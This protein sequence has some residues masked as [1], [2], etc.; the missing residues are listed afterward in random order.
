MATSPESSRKYFNPKQLAPYKPEAIKLKKTKKPTFI[1]VSLPDR[2][3]IAN[4]GA[5]SATTLFYFASYTR[6]SP[7]SVEEAERSFISVTGSLEQGRAR[8]QRAVEQANRILE[9]SHS[10]WRVVEKEIPNEEGQTKRVIYM[11]RKPKPKSPTAL[12]VDKKIR[13]KLMDRK[14]Y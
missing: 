3:S 10:P 6:I 1:E 12:E 5:D 7:L 8:L 11:H 13:I 14:P 9:N 4:T 2:S